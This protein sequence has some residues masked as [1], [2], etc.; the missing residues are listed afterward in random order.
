MMD[1]EWQR[2]IRVPRHLSKLFH[3]IN[4]HSFLIS[5]PKLQNIY[6]QKQKPKPQSLYKCVVLSTVNTTGHVY[7]QILISFIL[8]SGMVSSKLW[9]LP[10]LCA[11]GAPCSSSFKVPP[12]L[13]SE[14][15]SLFTD[16]FCWALCWLTHRARPM[17]LSFHWNWSGPGVCGNSP[18]PARPLAHT[19]LALVSRR[20]PRGRGRIDPQLSAALIPAPDPHTPPAA[21][22]APVN[23][24]LETTAP[25]PPPHSHRFQ[26]RGLQHAAV[27][28]GE[29]TSQQQ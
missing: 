21:A 24:R 16:A 7:P 11:P 22:A 25:T 4:V 20:M 13:Y 18:P 3:K 17:H 6:M 8:Q 5:M 9:T 19:W 23:W 27:V 1:T 10:T 26:W 28:P 15:P 14:R 2:N 29:E 12:W